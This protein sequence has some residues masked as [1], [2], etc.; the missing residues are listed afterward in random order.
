MK[1]HLF[2]TI[3]TLLIASNYFIN[4]EPVLANKALINRQA[5]TPFITKHTVNND[6]DFII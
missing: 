3:T 6:D 1:K 4:T 5:I 2:A